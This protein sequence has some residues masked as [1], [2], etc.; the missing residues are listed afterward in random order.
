MNK[1]KTAEMVAD[2]VGLDYGYVVEAIEYFKS[3]DEAFNWIFLSEENPM[4]PYTQEQLTQKLASV[5]IEDMQEANA[6]TAGE[7]LVIDADH[8]YLTPYG[9]AYI[10]I[11]R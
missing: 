11:T 2:M 10:R 9:V 7:Y 4:R 5:T 8:T 3:I 6:K 1:L